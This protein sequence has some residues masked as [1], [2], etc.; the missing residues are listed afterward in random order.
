M[1]DWYLPQ[2]VAGDLNEDMFAKFSTM[3]GTQ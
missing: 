2:T 1:N 3:S